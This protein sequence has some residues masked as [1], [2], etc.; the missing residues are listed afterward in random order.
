MNFGG[1]DALQQIGNLGLHVSQFG[2]DGAHL[3]IAAQSGV[4]G[5]QFVDSLLLC[6]RLD[7]K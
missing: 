1:L 7:L 3:L 5:F 2:R 6:C 4:L